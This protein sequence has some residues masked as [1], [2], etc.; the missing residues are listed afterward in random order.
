MKADD[1]LAIIKPPY[2]EDKVREIIKLAKKKEWFICERS[3]NKSFALDGKGKQV[4]K[5]LNKDALF[6]ERADEIISKPL[7]FRFNIK[8]IK[9]DGFYG[10]EY[11]DVCKFMVCRGVLKLK[12]I[13][14]N[15]EKEEVNVFERVKKDSCEKLSTETI[16]VNSGRCKGKYCSNCQWIKYK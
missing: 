11:M 15:E 7:G 8:K 5:L 9:E 16:E 10:E 12:K 3:I 13:F 6:N 2:D 14:I 1:I 4:F